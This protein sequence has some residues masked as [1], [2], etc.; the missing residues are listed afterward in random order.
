MSTP[1][2]DRIGTKI[3]IVSNGDIFKS[4]CEALVNPVN[5]KGVMGKGLAL[6]FKNKYPAHFEN[7]KRACQ[8]GEMTTQKVLAKEKFGGYPAEILQPVTL[9]ML[10]DLI[11][12]ET[13]GIVF[14]KRGCLSASRESLETLRDKNSS[15]KDVY[16]IGGHPVKMEVKICGE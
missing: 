7:Y 15:D 5:I 2:L 12:K 13:K 3:T 6:A 16:L 11:D 9:K 10:P 8:N 14:I 4:Q 1:K